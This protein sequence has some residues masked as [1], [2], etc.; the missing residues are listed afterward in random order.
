M[1]TIHL[2][3]DA[4]RKIRSVDPRLVSYNIEMAEVTGGTFWKAY[5][6][7]QLAG[8]E[9]FPPVSDPS[10]TGALMQVYPPIDL[11]SE[12]LRFL[13]KALG[14]VWVRVSG[15]WATSV[16]YDLDDRCGG[17]PPEGYK[18]VLTRSQW[19][20]VLDFVQA[21][22]AKLL[23]SAANC[24]GN[25]TSSEPWDPTQLD[26]LLTYSKTKGVPVAAV[27]FMNEPNMLEM[28]GAPAGYTAANYRRDQDTF[29]RFMRANYPEVPLVGPCPICLNHFR[30]VDLSGFSCCENE[31][32]LAGTSEPLNIYSY[33]C[34][35]GSSERIAAIGGHWQA[36]EAL[37]VPYLDVA[38]IVA[39]E[40]AEL[41]D[42]YCPNAPM[43]VTESGDSC[44]GGSTWA[45]TF[46]D[47]FRTL[48]ELGSFARITDGVIFHNTL[49]SSD[50]GLLA[51]EVFEPRPN[52]YAL[53]LWNRLMGSV[54]YEIDDTPQENVRVYAHSRKDGQ[55]GLA[56]VVLNM[57]SECIRVEMPAPAQQYTL[58]A[59]SLR[60]SVLRLNGTPLVLDDPQRLPELR[61]SQAAP[62]VVELPPYSATFFVL[63]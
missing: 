41:R 58:T 54:V 30:G 12:K 17:R 52:Y 27:E 43:W 47:I 60:S 63:S 38:A 35:N 50:Y 59:D 61:P 21:V 33:H 46:L 56:Y 4:L 62:G 22:G 31:A 49:A 37:S 15:T 8:T 7:G 1:N 14:P 53:L 44:G 20:G 10:D 39:R 36:D 23:I 3:M 48:N 16:Y 45:S 29:C 9:P 26:E 32:L 2:K 5:T 6:P 18:S 19:D 57:N 55:P 13:A 34:Y 25:H 28:S 40:N 11:S 51:R 24:A 42:K